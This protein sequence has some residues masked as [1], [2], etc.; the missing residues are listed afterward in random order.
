MPLERPG[1]LSALKAFAASHPGTR[2]GPARTA[3][4]RRALALRAACARPRAPPSAPARARASAQAPLPY[5]TLNCTGGDG[6]SGVP[7][8]AAGAHAGPADWPAR[9]LRRGL[10]GRQRTVRRPRA[11]R[12]RRAPPQAPASPGRRR[13]WFGGLQRMSAGLVVV[14]GL[15]EARPPSAA[16]YAPH[17]RRGCC[18][19]ACAPDLREGYC[20]VTPKRCLRPRA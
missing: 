18:S 19:A 2:V 1:A 7:R 16:A 11:A 9:R 4:R 8:V 14:L 15:W 3:G 17:L 12:R 10:R 20:S 5:H 13:T 6:G